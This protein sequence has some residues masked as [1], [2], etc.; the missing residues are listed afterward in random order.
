MGGIAIWI[1]GLP[2]CGKSTYAEGIKAEDPGFVI[3]RMDELR[4]LA[5]PSP[6]YTE[7]ERDIVYG[8][9]V[10]T[11]KTLVA[12]GHDVIIDATG[13]LRKWR[14]LAR[15]IL[16]KY[17]EVY[18]KCTLDACMERER[19]R[20]KTLGAPSGIYEK[21]RAGMPVPGAVAPYEEPLGPELSIDTEAVPPKEGISEVLRLAERLRGGGID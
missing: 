2:G 18:L 12:L 21:G 20:L 8:S 19:L 4:R 10:F 6:A 17:A 5:T 15:G 3:L 14:T 9:L 1:T 16:P 13:N 11:A 7:S